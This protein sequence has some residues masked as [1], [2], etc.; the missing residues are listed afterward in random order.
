MIL[1]SLKEYYDRNRIAGLIAQD[2][3]IRGG[4]D[5]LIDLDLGGNIQGVIDLR[6]IKGNKKIPRR[7]NVPNIGNQAL[8]HTN[9]AK[10]ANL[11]WDNAAFVFGLGDKGDL[12]L[13][14]MIDAIDKWLGDTSDYGVTA[15]RKFFIK[16]LKNR[17]HFTIALSHS[18][19]GEVLKKGNA[20]IS[21]RVPQTNVPIVF[22]T[23]I[24]AEA[25]NGAGTLYEEKSI[26]TVRG[27]C[28]VTGEKNVAIELTHPVTKGVWGTQVAG[29]CIVSFNKDAFNSYYKTQSLNAP[30]S[31]V[32]ASQY[33]KALN[34]LLDTPKQRIF[35]GDASTIFWSKKP[36]A[37]EADFG[38]FFKEPEK[39]DNNA[40]IKRVK[41]LFEAINSGAY[42]DK[43]GDT[44]FYVL[45]LAPNA[46][47]IV[48]RF[49]QMDTV[50]QFARQIK[51]YFDDFAIIKP[52][53][54]PEFYSMW[55][56]LVNI[57]AQDQS[58]NIPPNIAGDFLRAILT[59]TPFPATLL[60][61]VLRR[62]RSDTG[63]RVKPSRAALLKAYLNRYYRCHP[64]QKYKEIAMELDIYQ[65][66]I[67]YQLGRLFAALEKIQE[68]ATPGKNSTI[69]DRFYGAACATPITVFTNL[70]R[71]KNYHLAKF[72]NKKRVIYFEQLLGEIMG[73]LK[74][75]PDHLD[76]HEQ[77][78][79]ALGYYHQRQAF[80]A[81]RE[82]G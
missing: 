74:E 73:H 28:L 25:L 81:T 77:G 14:S 58:E 60:Q 3:W 29:G 39:Q 20:K 70:L 8:K 26:K 1:Q 59:G 47:R 78:R 67:G 42:L 2:G 36:T 17:N 31:K 53:K 71:L 44:P 32:V 22:E 69:R 10:D 68:E 80:F 33:S 61:A 82:V 43:D 75:F 27:T 15:V 30:V 23:T 38:L 5:F 6:E 48:V 50:S 9:S 18:E 41:M 21:F 51:Q 37:F 13:Q 35:I 49:W 56:I 16:G 40:G 65:P 52:P 76:L 79:F 57:A 55:R 63:N 62:M 72:I 4:I 54:E 7:V 46:A 12:R 19:Y 34:A 11:L 64:N 66:S 45:G 24:V